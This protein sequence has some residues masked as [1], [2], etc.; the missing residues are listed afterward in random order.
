[1]STLANIAVPS[2]FTFVN[3]TW[4]KSK[5]RSLPKKGVAIPIEKIEALKEAIERLVPNTEEE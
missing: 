3:G 4:I 5:K 1:M 2:I